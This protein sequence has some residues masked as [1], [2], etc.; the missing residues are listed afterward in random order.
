M[1]SILES[2]QVFAARYTLLRRI[3]ASLA[4]ELWLARDDETGQ[5]RVLKIFSAE[6][7]DSEA[8][9]R[10]LRAS[11]AQ[12]Q[13]KHPNL[14]ACIDVRDAPQPFA[15][16]EYAPCGDASQLRGRPW[17][18]VIGVLQGIAQGSAAVHDAGL[19]HRDLKLSNVLLSDDGRPLLS[20][21]GIAVSAGDTREAAAGSP[22]SSSPQQ[23]AGSPPAFSD[24]IYSF[25]TLAWELLSG[26]PPAYTEGVAGRPTAEPSPG[27]R[28]PMPARLEQL[29][30][31]CLSPKAT[32]RP[33]DFRAI[34]VELAAIGKDSA[35]SAPVAS[36]RNDVQLKI[37]RSGTDHIEA[38]WR[39][40]ADL[41]PSEAELRSQGFRRGLVT[42]AL[43]L[44][45][46]AAGLVFFALPQWVDRRADKVSPAAQTIRPSAVQTSGE[47]AAANAGEPDLK[48]LAELKRQF[49]QLSPLLAERYSHLGEREAASWDGQR[50]AR[51][52][53]TLQ[54]ATAAAAVHDYD[55][56]LQALKSAGSDIEAMESLAG[57]RLGEALDAGNA[58]LDA[59]SATEAAQHFELALKLDPASERARAGLKRAASLNQVRQLVAQGSELERD[60]NWSA[61]IERYRDA[62]KLD[63]ATAGAR[64]SV[65]RLEARMAGDEFAA[66]VARG[67]SALS[68]EDFEGASQAFERAARLRPGSAEAR[69]GLARVARAVDGRN[70]SILLERAQLAEQQERWS[71]ALAAY[72]KALD[73]DRNLLAAQQGVE[74]TEPRAMIDAELS[75][76]IDSPERLNTPAVREA[77][78]ASLDRAGAIVEPGQR[79]QR[80]MTTLSGMIEVSQR[81]VKIALASDKQTDVTIYRIGRLGVFESKEMEL[82]PGKYTV[83]GSREGY[84]DVRRELMVQP[85]A[86]PPVLVIRCEDRI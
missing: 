44:L 85:G 30:R 15:V 43:I 40:A 57:D 50:F 56:A 35:G 77:A 51:A 62:L 1:P 64:E 46:L 80:Q 12:R 11:R 66:A 67:M 45:I 7:T 6:P 16:L 75:A 48:A 2:G 86:T 82:L 19:V 5:Q 37:P 31:R 83:V 69:D 32:D 8:A 61:A 34:T 10:F 70:I 72:R 42:G 39:K 79:L 54:Q 24:D 4:A 13:L 65:V 78:Q 18:E 71:E 60:G 22:L 21:F 58:A 27:M 81:P 74:R 29:L 28:H 9:A 41:G 14:L 55:S 76:F 26:Y 36:G 73:I 38:A 59:G 84:R 25:G 3:A 63:P 68:R 17:R 47:R 20:D 49:D 53:S 52:G 33:A 23:A